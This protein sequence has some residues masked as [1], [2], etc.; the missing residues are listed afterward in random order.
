M[1]QTQFIIIRLAIKRFSDRT[2]DSLPAN[3]WRG[4]SLTK[5]HASTTLRHINPTEIE[6][7]TALNKPEI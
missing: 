4:K 7:L 2:H 5:L 1:I 6:H 3:L